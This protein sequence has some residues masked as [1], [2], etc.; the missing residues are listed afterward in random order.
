[1]K[2]SVSPAVIAI[3]VVA[4]LALVIFFG[5]KTMDSSG[6][7]DTAVGV[8]KD[9][10]PMSSADGEAMMKRMRGDTSANPA[11]AAGGK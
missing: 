8:G 11:P 10:K 3:A 9:G 2:Q 4:I 7:G 6:G 5:K 1:M